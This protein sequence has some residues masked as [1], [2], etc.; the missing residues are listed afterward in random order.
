VAAL[1]RIF[2]VSSRLLSSELQGVAVVMT[3]RWKEFVDML[4][5]VQSQQPAAVDNTPAPAR[6]RADDDDDVDYSLP[7]SREDRSAGARRQVDSKKNKDE[8]RSR[9]KD[10]PSENRDQNRDHS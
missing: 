9:A 2:V 7:S 10:Q 5:A 3:H 6:Q 4:K 1:V 8:V